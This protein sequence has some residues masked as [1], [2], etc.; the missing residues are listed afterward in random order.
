MYVHRY[1]HRCRRPHSRRV[2]QR[3]IRQRRQRT[4]SAPQ[5]IKQILK[6]SDIDA[7][8]DVDEVILGQVLTAGPGAEPGAAGG[9]GRVACRTRRP[10]GAST[11][12]AALVC[13]RWRSATSRSPTATPRSSSPAA[14]RTCRCRRTPSHMRS[15]TQDGRHQAHRHDDQGR[16]DGRLPGL[17]HG[18]DG[19]EHRH[20]LAD[21]ARGAGQVRPRPR[22][23]RPR[24]RRRPPSS[25]TRSS[26]IT[27][28]GKKG[29]TVVDQDEYIRLNAVL[30]NFSKLRPAFSKDGTVTAGNASGINDGAAG[31][32]LMSAA[33]AKKRGL[34]PLARIAS[35]AT[36]GVDPAVMGTGPIPASR[37][38]LEKAGWKVKDLDLVEANEAFAAQAISV[39]KDM[40]W[41]PENR[42]RQRRRHRHRSSDRRV[43]APAS[44]SPCCTRCR[45]ATP[46]RASPRCASAAAWAS[47]SASSAKRLRGLAEKIRRPRALLRARPRTYQRLKAGRESPPGAY[48]IDED[49]KCRRVA[50]VS[51]GSRGIGAAISKALKER[52][53]H[54]RRHLCGQ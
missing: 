26:R 1:R 22:R 27:I 41:D 36:A 17:P 47:R 18:H 9:D 43:R 2:L 49:G 14:R 25:R 21:L 3:R 19:R 45:S 37:K 39:N 33:E 28:S 53:A 38:A 29:D 50:V 23:T 20:T 54:G 42:E 15:G 40:G 11:R 34:T 44:S 32:V 8:D 10:R 52:G 13:V 4:T 51:G 16:P 35:W 48:E 24:R 31:V 5:V 12:C 46:R 6:T 7:G 30:E